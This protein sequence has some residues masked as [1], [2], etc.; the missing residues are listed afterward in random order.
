MPVETIVIAGGGLAGWMAAS[1]LSRQIS[2]RLTDI[3]VIDDGITD[4]SLGPPVPALATLPSARRFHAQ[5]GYDED[6]IINATGGGFSLGTAISGWTQIGGGVFHPF[7]ETG[8]NIGHVSFHHLAARL[9]AEGVAIN[10]A[11]YAL[12]ALCAQTSR[13]IRPLPDNR[14]VLSTLNY[15]LVLNAARYCAMFKLDAQANDVTAIDAAILGTEFGAD[16]LVASV[17]T[18]AGPIAADLFLDCTGS[19]ATIIG[20]LPSVT[21]QDWSR[22][23]PCDHLANNSLTSQDP[24]LP[25]AHLAAQ[26]AGWGMFLSTIGMQH[27]NVVFHGASTPDQYSDATAYLSGRRSTLWQGNVIALGAAAAVID[28]LSPL[29]L[30]MLHSAIQQLI[31]LLPAIKAST[32][33]ASHFNEVITAELNCARDF[34]IMPYKLNGRAGTPFWDACCAMAVPDTLAHKIEL[35]RATGRIAL[36]DG[37]A[38]TEAD[39]VACLDAQGIYPARYDPAANAI[40]VDHIQ[41]HFARIRQ[42]MLGELR[43]MPF[44]AAYLESISR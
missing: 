12:G 19:S 39:W 24:P 7:G 32:V 18:D 9:R 6:T 30:H 22:W 5:F 27:E 14:S 33:E 26:D 25:Y 28:P 41:Q 44:H 38:M 3:I 34:A 20:A 1:V 2:R 17:A 15:A 36:Y 23:L 8:A 13:F 16:G 35:Y 37:E 4:D 31:T 29:S 40:P 42:V 43:Q 21:F 10:L 11:D